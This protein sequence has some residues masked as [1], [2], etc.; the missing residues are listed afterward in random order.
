MSMTITEQ[1]DADPRFQDMV[2][3]GTAGNDVFTAW[4]SYDIAWVVSSTI[5]ETYEQDWI[6]YGG[7]GNDTLT[8]GDEDDHVDGGSDN[9]V[10]YGMDGED[11]LTGGNGNDVLYGGAMADT[12]HG[13]AGSDYLYG[14]AGDDDLMGEEG[15]WAAYEGA[16]ATE[17]L[18]DK[19]GHDY[20]DGGA[21]NNRLYGGYGSDTYVVRSN[22]DQVIERND[23]LNY[24]GQADGAGLFEGK[25]TVLMA[26]SSYTLPQYVED[27]AV[28][29]SWNQSVTMNGNAL[30]NKL[31]GGSYADVL[32]GGA[33]NDVLVGGA[34][35]DVMKGGMDNDTYEVTESGDQVVEQTGEGIDLVQS[36]LTAYTLPANVENI[37]IFTPAAADATGNSMAN[38]ITGNLF[39]NTLRGMAGNDTIDGFLGDDFIYG[40]EGDDVL[41]G[42]YGADHVYGDAGNDE[43]SGSN[44]ADYLFGGT[45]NDTIRGGA[46]NDQISGGAGR[47]MLFGN[48]GNDLFIFS[49]T[50]ESNFLLFD[51]IKDFAPGQDKIDLSKIDANTLT[52]GNQ[53]FN[54]S[55]SKPFFTS[56]GDLWVEAGRGSCNVYADVN[57]DGVQDMH[58]EVMGIN[59]LSLA[60]F[61][62]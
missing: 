55:A 8:G 33:G 36:F 15:I 47:D 12:L 25:D 48:A 13:G 56:A 45:G 20:L 22:G 40:G 59:T 3:T 57:G 5:P 29:E 34:G 52:T 58:I 38:T 43:L 4:A 30:S 50:S 26:M 21:G 7:A 32:I 62:V 44:G 1:P 61:I 16:Y 9:D 11:Y 39:A 49:A 2:A 31:S 28:H 60:D 46:D 27:L 10:L 41:E 18:V 37:Q 51:T 14:G 42:N 35:Q 19:T 24:V 54:F 53:A 6:I 23:N 17:F